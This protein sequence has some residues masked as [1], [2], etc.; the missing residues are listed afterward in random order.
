MSVFEKL[1]PLLQIKTHAKV[2]QFSCSEGKQ[3]LSSF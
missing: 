2:Y 1:L 3:I